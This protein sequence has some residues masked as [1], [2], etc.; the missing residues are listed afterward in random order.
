LQDF[1]GG[2]H[3]FND[4]LILD[5]GKVAVFDNCDNLRQK[6]VDSGKASLQDLFIDLTGGIADE[7]IS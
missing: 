7:S 3:G 2:R 6:R 4:V 1:K 5:K